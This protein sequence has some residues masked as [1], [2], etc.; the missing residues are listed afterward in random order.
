[1]RWAMMALPDTIQG[2]VERKSNGVPISRTERNQLTKFLAGGPTK[3]MPNTLSNKQILANVMKGT[4]VGPI[5]W[6]T[7]SR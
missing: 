3:K 1:M 6:S 2:I 4:H 7:P 5:R